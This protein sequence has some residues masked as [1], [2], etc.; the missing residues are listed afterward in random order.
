[1]LLSLASPVDQSNSQTNNNLD[2]P[3]LAGPQSVG[4][5]GAS[6]D[7]A[8]VLK[9]LT[10][11]PVTES[12]V[13]NTP[14]F[15]ST[16]FLNTVPMAEVES[17][18]ISIQSSNI[19]VVPGVTFDE[20]DNQLQMQPATNF[21][22]FSSNADQVQAD[23][24]IAFVDSP[25]QQPD[26]EYIINYGDHFWDEVNG[27]GTIAGNL[28]VMSHINPYFKSKLVEAM[29]KKIYSDKSI[30]T[31]IGGFNDEKKLSTG[32]VMNMTEL[33]KFAFRTAVDQG[34]LNQAVS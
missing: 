5:M 15:D 34:Y 26:T 33:Q 17:P 4:S 6:F 29:L 24:G 18:V 23:K 9:N 22:I 10:T 12:T 20:V 28:E 7:Y 2:D 21:K 14:V 25:E 16:S 30:R 13:T 8:T 11:V 32:Q 31:K 1:M 19:E 3:V 27:E